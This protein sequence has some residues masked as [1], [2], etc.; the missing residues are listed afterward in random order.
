MEVK[1]Y[2]EIYTGLE[3]II[4]I[5]PGHIY[6]KDI[7]GLFVACNNSQANAAGFAHASEMIGKSDYDMPW[8]DNA[9]EIRA[10]DKEVIESKQP[11]TKKEVSILSNGKKAVYLS[12]K[13]PLVNKE[14]VV[15]GIL[16]ISIEI[17]NNNNII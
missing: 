16:G 8:K 4:S 11:Q 2:D 13:V 15:I 10:N 3:T 7:Y 6:W 5:F 12:Q 17:T 14:G 1:V 9:D